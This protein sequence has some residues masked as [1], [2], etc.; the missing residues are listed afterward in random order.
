[1]TASAQAR[2]LQPFPATVPAAKHML[3]YLP[4]LRRLDKF[5]IT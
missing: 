4:G 2:A 3:F 1:M 5:I